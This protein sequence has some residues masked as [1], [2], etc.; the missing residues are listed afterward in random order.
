MTS[1]ISLLITILVFCLI[2]SVV[3]YAVRCGIA[4]LGAPKPVYNLFYAIVV[5]LLLLVF[6][7][8]IGYLGRAYAW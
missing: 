6:L 2:A 7:S 8:K 5:L 4:A 3:L 1:L